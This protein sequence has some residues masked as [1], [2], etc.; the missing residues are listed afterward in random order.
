MAAYQKFGQEHAAAI[1]GGAVLHPTATATTVRV[2][3]ARGGN[4]V[5]GE[6]PVRRRRTWTS[7]GH[8]PMGDGLL[9]GRTARNG[10][11][12]M[13]AVKPW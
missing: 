4:V 2:T 12:R 6:G 11:T 3:G 7:K 5:T 1:R 10:T 8:F 9:G 13:T